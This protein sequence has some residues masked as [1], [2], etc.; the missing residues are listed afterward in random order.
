MP[1]LQWEGGGG[2]GGRAGSGPLGMASGEPGI[3]PVAQCDR[4]HFHPLPLSVFQLHRLNWFRAAQL[5]EER[6][7]QSNIS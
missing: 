3:L 5:N 4:Q 7:D 2:W 1:I 6:K